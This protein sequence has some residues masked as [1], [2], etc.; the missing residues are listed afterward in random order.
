MTRALLCLS[1]LAGLP[2]CVSEGPVEDYAFVG[3]WDCEVETFTFTNTTYSYADKV[4]PIRSVARDGRNYT[5]Y[6]A[7]GYV[8]GLGAVTKTGLTWVS[9]ASG[10]QFNCKRVN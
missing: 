3:T 6:F 10:D 9:G 7:D 8:I 1:A 4:L 2:A 5:L